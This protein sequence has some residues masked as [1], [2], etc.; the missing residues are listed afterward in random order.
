MLSLGWLVRGKTFT[1]AFGAENM[2]SNAFETVADY[3]ESLTS[4]Q[5]REDEKTAAAIRKEAEGKGIWEE[6][7]AAARSF[8]VNPIDTLA[9]VTGSALPFAA[10]ARVRCRYPGLALGALGALSGAGNS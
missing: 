5:S 8:G 4:A 1:D 6:V 3:A 9:S 7:K 10:A 2:A